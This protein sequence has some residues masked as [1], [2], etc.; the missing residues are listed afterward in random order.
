MRLVEVET[1]AVAAEIVATAAEEE[2]AGIDVEA[3]DEEDD[4]EEDDDGGEHDFAAEG[5]ALWVVGVA[6]PSKSCRVVRVVHFYPII[7]FSDLKLF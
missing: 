1:A 2:A 5:V 4:G 6:F 7:S 3:E